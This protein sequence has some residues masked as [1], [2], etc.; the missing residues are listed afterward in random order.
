[1]KQKKGY[2]GSSV[3]VNK[4]GANFVNCFFDARDGIDT[5]G[6]NTENEIAARLGRHVA[7]KS[8]DSVQRAGLGVDGTAHIR[9]E[10]RFFRRAVRSADG[11]R[12][13]KKIKVIALRK[14]IAAGKSGTAV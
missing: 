3:K 1:M 10:S 5:V 11:Q 14:E 8:G 12:V 9:A 4:K 7:G 13:A 6:K 2:G